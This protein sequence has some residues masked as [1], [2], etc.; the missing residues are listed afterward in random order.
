MLAASL[1]VAGV[2]RAGQLTD[3]DQVGCTVFGAASSATGDLVTFESTCDLTGQ[4]A[5]GNREIFQVDDVG[6]VTQLTDSTDCTNANVT[7]NS[8]GQIVAFD[9]DCDLTGGN[10]DGNVEIFTVKQGAIVQLT[11]SADCGSF[12]PSSSQ[13]GARIAFDSD[14]D[15]LGGAN[16]YRSNEIFQI[17]TTTLAVSQLTDDRSSTYCGS[18]NAASNA[19]G[20]IVAFES[21]C[22]LTGGNPDQIPEIFEV[23]AGNGVVTQLTASDD[24]GCVSE[25]V[26]SNANGSVFVFQ[27][28]CDYTGANADGSEE[29]FQ[30]TSSGVVEQLTD[31]ASAS[32]CESL[33]P[34]V[35]STGSAVVFMSWCD[36]L[37]TNADGS[38]ELFRVGGG[39]MEQITAGTGCSSVAPA[40]T[41]NGA[42]VSY[43][44]D[45][46]PDGLNADGSDEVFQIGVCG[47]CGA[48]ISG[49][50]PPAAPT[51]TDALFVLRAGVGIAS[52][53]LCEC[54]VDSSGKVSATDALIVLK[55]SVGQPVSLVCS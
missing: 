19:G 36:P 40:L 10:G 6:F 28:D 39:V 25:H 43:T 1:A 15:Y 16:P 18:F 27:S 32:F 42:I 29:V 50:E 26:S 34:V 11:S 24:D 44:S 20:G 48:P 4:N 55:A 13:T 17:D 5:D 37:G 54:D 7:S 45:C 12:A 14:C 31:D 49:N 23:L 41:T 22:D 3:H 52:C 21:D 2:A 9:S 47:V 30:V 33:R 46:N 53:E 51:A 8:T 38:F 35:N